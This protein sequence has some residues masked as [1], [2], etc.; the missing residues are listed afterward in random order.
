[1]R[2]LLP[3]L[4]LLMLAP[5]APAGGG[6]DATPDT[7]TMSK[8]DLQAMI[9]AEV[10]KA[11][12]AATAQIETWQKAALDG[13]WEAAHTQHGV[14]EALRPLVRAQWE[15]IKPAEG[16]HRPDPAVWLPDQPFFSA[17]KP[18][19]PPAAPE[20]PKASGRP[21]V[22]ATPEAPKAPAAPATPAAPAAPKAPTAP[23][24]PAYL[25]RGPGQTGTAPAAQPAATPKDALNVAVKA[26]IAAEA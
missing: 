24:L 17:L 21:P 3:G 22:A 16:E 18:A 12:A 11:T 8:A 25:Q 5:D 6:N 26:A 23:A 1:M 20:A 19:A 14:P 9:L 7:V 10:T 15:A 4:A 2:S 13:A